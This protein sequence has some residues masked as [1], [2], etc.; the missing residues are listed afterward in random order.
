MSIQDRDLGWKKIRREM[1]AA[2]GTETV[3]GIFGHGGD[4]SDDLAARAAVHEYG[5]EKMNIPS[6]PFMRQTYENNKDKIG[7]VQASLYAQ[8]LSGRFSFKRGLS[9][10]GEWYTDRIQQTIRRGNFQPLKPATILAKGS[11]KPLID[12]KQMH[13]AV[14]HKET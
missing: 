9:R 13:N 1:L 3:V 6:R 14:T 11:S 10:L 5:S 7:R 2:D 12:T 8:V 4:A